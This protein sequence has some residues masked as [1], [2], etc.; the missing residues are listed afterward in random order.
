MIKLFGLLVLLAFAFFISKVGFVVLLTAKTFLY[1][2]AA[3]LAFGLVYWAGHVIADAINKAQRMN[4][5]DNLFWK[6]K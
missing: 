1:I 2:M 4:S 3:F 5:E 6:K